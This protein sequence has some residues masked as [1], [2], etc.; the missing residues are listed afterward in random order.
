MSGPNRRILRGLACLLAMLASGSSRAA[1]RPTPPSGTGGAA[2]DR[3]SFYTL[4]G[5]DPPQVFV[6]L[7]PRTVEE[8]RQIEALTDYSAARA[9]EHE[10]LWSDAIALLEKAL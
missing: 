1:D 7:H 5:E 2:A 6:P 8:R 9:F 4:P 3:A 10:N